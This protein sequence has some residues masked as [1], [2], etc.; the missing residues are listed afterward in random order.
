MSHV[1]MR[2]ATLVLAAVLALSAPAAAQI[3]VTPRPAPPPAPASRLPAAELGGPSPAASLRP[4]AQAPAQG[5]APAV[6][7]PAAR[8]DSSRGRLWAPEMAGRSQA[9]VGAHDND[10]LVKAIESQMRCTCGCNLDV[11]TCRTT[12]FTCTTSPA[13]H[14]VVL[15]RL[16]SGMTAAQVIDAFQKQYGESVMMEPPKHGFNWAAYIMPFVGLL[17]GL[18]IV[19]FVMRGWFRVKPRGPLEGEAEGAPDASAAPAA[20]DDEMQRLRQELERF[21]A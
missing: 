17:V 15:A 9:V 16:D 1:S 3:R 19:A 2:S 14:R 13:M 20:T 18:V 8:P 7:A 21:E 10:S 11:F 4:A 6:G 12:D 5:A